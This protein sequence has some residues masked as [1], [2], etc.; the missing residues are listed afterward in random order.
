MLPFPPCN[1]K[2]RCDGEILT[3]RVGRHNTAIF[4]EPVNPNLLKIILKG[5]HVCQENKH[6]SIDRW[7]C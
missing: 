2:S 7:A 5:G 3:L 4:L 6:I 1:S